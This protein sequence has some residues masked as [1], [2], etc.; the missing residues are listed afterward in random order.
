MN[1]P[2]NNKRT[3]FAKTVQIS[4]GQTSDSSKGGLS[5]VTKYTF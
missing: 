5:T 4:T 2:A 3:H 1:P